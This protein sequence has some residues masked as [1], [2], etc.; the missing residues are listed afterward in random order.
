MERTE[1]VYNSAHETRARI[2]TVPSMQAEPFHWACQL[3]VVRV[4]LPLWLH[5]HR[6]AICAKA[7]YSPADI[8]IRL[9]TPPAQHGKCRSKMVCRL[10]YAARTFCHNPALQ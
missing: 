9:C 5:I 1:T 7:R 4:L 6:R 10:D 3:L 2:A 8:S